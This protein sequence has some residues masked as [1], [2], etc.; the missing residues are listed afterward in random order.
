MSRRRN[1]GNVAIETAIFI[2]ILLLLIVGMVQLGKVTYLYYTLKKMVYAAARQVSVQ[3][4]INFCDV[5][6]DQTVQSAIN[7]AINDTAGTPI[8]A[9]LTTLQV[10]TQCTDPNNV[11]GAMIPCDTSNCDALTVAARPDF[12]T[13]SI[14]GGYPVNVLIPFI[15]PIPVTLNPTV[16][17]PFGGVS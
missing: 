4:S 1:H 3:Q 16:T 7:F 17:V 15:S 12:V 2:P 5:T 9:N 14:P 10:T 8:I 6:N 11:G 13:V